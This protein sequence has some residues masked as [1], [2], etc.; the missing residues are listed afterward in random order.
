MPCLSLICN[1]LFNIIDYLR[2]G[3]SLRLVN[4]NQSYP[5]GICITGMVE[6]LK[7]SIGLEIDRLGAGALL[8][9]VKTFVDTRQSISKSPYA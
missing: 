8:K 5:Q 9:N 7:Y 2:I 4:H 1:L 6:L 3:N